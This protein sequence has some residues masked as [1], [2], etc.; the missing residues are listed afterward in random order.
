MQKLE[1]ERE[2]LNLLK[3]FKIYLKR[4]NEEQENFT[5]RNK[6]E[7]VSREIDECVNEKEQKLK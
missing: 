2:K 7:K 3:F 6:M 5:K 1:Y 4:M